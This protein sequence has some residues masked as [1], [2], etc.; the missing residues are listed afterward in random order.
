MNNLNL[1]KS[2]SLLSDVDPITFVHVNN[3]NS[4]EDHML[5]INNY[6]EIY[7]YISGETDYI[8]KDSYYNLE[9]GD[10]IVISPQELHKAVLRERCKYERFYMLIPSNTFKNFAYDPINIILK[11][12]SLQGSKI[13]LPDEQR[14]VALDI[15]YKISEICSAEIDSNTE[16]MAYSMLLQFL[17]VLI[18]NVENSNNMTEK[19]SSNI[20]KLLSDVLVYIYQNLQYIQTASEVAKHFNITPQY[21]SSFFKKYTGTTIKIYIRTQKIA[22]AKEL[23]T[24]DYSVTDACYESGFNDC[25]YFIKHFKQC[26]GMTPLRYKETCKKND[27][28][29]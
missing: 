22:Y 15:L 16:M 23:L 27:I 6:V 7:V 19:I 24:K 26:T 11:R 9:K 25:S 21:L 10:I 17:C 4:P 2:L 12:S 18:T 5:H 29:I 1:K 28:K 14:K 13:S 8:V 3:T 20:P